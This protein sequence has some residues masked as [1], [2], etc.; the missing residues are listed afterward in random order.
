MPDTGCQCLP[1]RENEPNYI[2]RR[3]IGCRSWFDLH[4]LLSLNTPCHPFLRLLPVVEKLSWYHA[5]G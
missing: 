4:R 5:K 3:E 1:I 2:P